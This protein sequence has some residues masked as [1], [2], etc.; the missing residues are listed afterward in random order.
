MEAE[1]AA[2]VLPVMRE[3]LVLKRVVAVQGRRQGWSLKQVCLLSCW[4]MGVI[5][6]R[7]SNTL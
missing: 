5:S 3:N 1:R 6:R 4:L 7:L 2:R